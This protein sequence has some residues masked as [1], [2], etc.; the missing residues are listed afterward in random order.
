MAV[1]D[2]LS[3]EAVCLHEHVLGSLHGIE[4]GIVPV[5]ALEPLLFPPV[6]G[7]ALCELERV[8]VDVEWVVVHVV[9]VEAHYFAHG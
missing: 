9:E 5:A 3:G 8:D 7:S 4:H 6:I 1:N 2:C